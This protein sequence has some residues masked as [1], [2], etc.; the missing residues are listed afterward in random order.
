MEIGPLIAIIASMTNT[1]GLN[2]VTVINHVTEDCKRDS[3]GAP[4]IGTRNILGVV[5][6]MN[7]KIFM[8]RELATSI[9]VVSIWFFSFSAQNYLLFQCIFN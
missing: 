7:T 5:Y 3:D 9:H 4:D 8:I 6:G 2:G 1:D